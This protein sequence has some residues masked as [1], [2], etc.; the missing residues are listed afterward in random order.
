[1]QP[2]EKAG[3]NCYTKKLVALSMDGAL[4]SPAT[5]VESIK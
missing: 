2:H 5:K 4:L 1:M 3:E